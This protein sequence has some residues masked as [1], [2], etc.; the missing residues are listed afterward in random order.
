MV[1]GSYYLTLKKDGEPGEGKVFR[2]VNEA[3]MAYDQHIVSLHAAIKV[4]IT[5]Q[6]RRQAGIKDNRRYSRKTYLQRAIIPQNLGFVDRTN[7]EK[8]F[9]LE[10][11]FLVRKKQLSDIID[12]CIKMH[13]TTTDFRGS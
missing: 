11:G 6:T 13:G 4:R 7:S 12:K 9:D 5:K 3:L 1:L 10:I 8:Q 2:D